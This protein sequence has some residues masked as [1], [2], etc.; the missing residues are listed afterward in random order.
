[1]ASFDL[2]NA[3]IQMGDEKLLKSLCDLWETPRSISTVQILCIMNQR[4]DLLHSLLD[5]YGK[6]GYLSHHAVE[7]GNPE[8]IDAILHF[9]PRDKLTLFLFAAK[10]GNVEILKAVN[11]HIHWETERYSTTIDSEAMIPAI[12]F[13]LVDTALDYLETAKET[14]RNQG[15]LEAVEFLERC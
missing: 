13:N 7:Y 1:M 4:N 9:C 6:C 10:S 11:R 2:L 14:A 8:C 3:K 5:R 12:Q 15:H